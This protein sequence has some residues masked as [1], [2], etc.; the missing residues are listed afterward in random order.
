MSKFKVGDRVRCIEDSAWPEQYGRAGEEYNV[1]EVSCSGS[2][3]VIAG[4]SGAM[5]SRFELVAP[6]TAAMT[7]QAGK[8]YKTRDGRK[9]GPMETTYDNEYW[10]FKSAGYYFKRDGFSC[11]GQAHNHKDS[12]DLIAEWVDEPAPIA[13][14]FKVGD[15]VRYNGW[16]ANA[17]K[18]GATA[19]VEAVGDEFLT[20]RWVRDGLDQ[21]QFDGGYYPHHFTVV[22][23]A[24][25]GPTKSAFKV[26]DRV[27]F[28]ADNPNCG[29]EFGAAGD[30]ATVEAGLDYVSG[31]YGEQ[32]KVRLEKTGKTVSAP[33][34]AL[35]PA[36][37]TIPAPGDWVKDQDGRIGIVFHDDG[38]DYA[39]L[40][41]GMTEDGDVE[42]YS[43]RDL[44]IVPPG[45]K[46]A[47][48]VPVAAN[49]N[50]EVGDIVEIVDTSIFAPPVS[51]GDLAAVTDTDGEIAIRVQTKTGP[52]GQ[53]VFLEHTNHIRPYRRTS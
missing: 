46:R 26:G 2:I 5:A 28:T 41:V 3:V 19:F 8:F 47:K 22:A 23:D 39:N 27:R 31:Y 20:L 16:G 43:P 17:A 48:P 35:E 12:D 40:K 32:V 45:T 13:R 4:M 34:K 53:V 44:T 1:L 29:A 24:A 25:P 42:Y 38:D 51:V 30:Y 18:E 10:P 50:Y 21:Q 9:V 33:I 6:A 36:T 15:K 49:D 52:V 14:A 7:I 11:P 37:P